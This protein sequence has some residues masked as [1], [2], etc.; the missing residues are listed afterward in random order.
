MTWGRDREQ[1]MADRD[2][3]VGRALVEIQPVD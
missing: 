2:P 3:A 1:A